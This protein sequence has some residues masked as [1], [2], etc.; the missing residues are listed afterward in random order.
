M[1]EGDSVFRAAAQL[2]TS[3]PKLVLAISGSG[4]DEAR[5]V[6]FG[7]AHTAHV[8]HIDPEFSHPARGAFVRRNQVQLVQQQ[9]QCHVL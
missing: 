3:R 2:R 9:W 4:R 7:V 6:A 1:P 8:A 5:H